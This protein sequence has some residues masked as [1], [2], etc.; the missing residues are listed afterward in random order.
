VRPP[1]R[2]EARRSALLEATIQL[3]GRDGLGAVTH[4]SVAALAGV[5][6]ATTSYYFP[7]KERLV[8]EALRTLGERELADLRRR[9][10]LLGSADLETTADA[11]ATW[12]LDHVAEDGGAA[13]LAEHELQLEAARRPERRARAAVARE[14]DALAERALA[15]LGASDPPLAALLLISAIDGLE[16]RLL[17]G[18]TRLAQQ[19]TLRE[20][21]AGLLRALT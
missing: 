19:G 12:L 3:I 20:A 21:I 5:P 4:R 15:D 9:H 10:D 1:V 17:A 6:A 7:S 8:E 14:I 11:L 13:V 18:D 16:L 2:G